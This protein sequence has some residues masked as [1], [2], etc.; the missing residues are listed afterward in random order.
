MSAFARS[1]C[2]PGSMRITI[3]D[4]VLQPLIHVHEKIDGAARR[5]VDGLQIL[6]QA[7]A[8]RLDLAETAASSRSSAVLV[9][10]GHFS[11]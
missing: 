7:R 6:G 8:G 5:H 11:A 10:N 9:R 2:T 3:A 4:L 1:I